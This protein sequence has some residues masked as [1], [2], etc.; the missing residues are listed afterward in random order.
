MDNGTDLVKTALLCQGLICIHEYFKN[1]NTAEQQTAQK[2]D[3]L[4]K[5]VEWNWFTQGE[6]VLYWH[7]SSEFNFEINLP[8][9]GYNEDLIAYIFGAA[10]PTHPIDAAVYHE[11][12]AQ[13]GVI[14]SKAQQYNIPVLLNHGGASDSVGPLFWV[15]YSYL[16][17]DPRGLIDLYANYWNVVHNHT[18]IVLEHCIQNPNEFSGYSDKNSG[19]PQVILETQTGVTA[20]LITVQRTIEGLL[21]QLQH[22]LHSHILQRRL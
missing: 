15:Y 19:L 4:W 7:W 14:K 9:V 2:A 8:I 12:W 10:S 16:T 20:I 3:A 13:N 21:V 6:N 11:G 1:G 18:Q 17:L 22:L 5:G